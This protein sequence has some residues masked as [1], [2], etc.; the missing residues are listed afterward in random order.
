MNH[1]LVIDDEPG[2]RNVLKDVLEDEDY[3]VSLAE[4]GYQGLDVLAG[5][6]VDLVILDVWLPNLGGIDVLKK[7]KESHRDTE[8]VMISG[9]AN[10]GLAVRAVK[11][12]AF[13]FLEKP[14]SL[15]KTITVTKNALKMRDLRTENRSL[16][17]SL[18]LEDEM[19]GTGRPIMKV[20]ELIAQSASSD[21][22]VL[23]TG[24]NGTGKELVAR[25]I[26]QKSGRSDFPF[27]EVNCAAIP[28]S[29]I[30]SELFG[31]EKGAFTGAIARRKG[32]FELAHN[33]TLFLD[34]IADMSLNTQAKILRVIQ[35]L[36]FERIGGEEPITVDVR[37]ITATNKEVEQEIQAKRFREDLYYRINVI[38]IHVPPLRERLEDIDDLADY[39]MEKYNHPPGSPPKRLTRETV[40]ELKSYQWPGNIR[41]LKNFIERV[42][43][44]VEDEEISPEI[45]RQYLGNFTR[46]DKVSDLAKY[47]N[48]KL[49]EAK[50][51]FESEL[52]SIKLKQFEGNITKTAENLGIYPSNLYGKIKKFG[53]SLERNA[54]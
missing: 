24:E 23:I 4:D 6:G 13:D 42:N 8:V 30:E 35:E 2:I 43:I 49:N 26:H 3:R 22:R 15:D 50:D 12:G 53:I 45:I 29:L 41:E 14:L 46:T 17:N 10:V 7:I 47:V 40:D 16:K 18:F 33:G 19:I 38:P 21:S 52:I 11:I 31:H 48:M 51:L 20:R 54:L 39:F 27:V 1:I 44:M 34:E 5:D 36:K 37:L 32:K 25:Q 9:H 28:E